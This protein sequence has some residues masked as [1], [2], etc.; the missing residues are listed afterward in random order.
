MSSLEHEEASTC[1]FCSKTCI[2]PDDIMRVLCT[3][4]WGVVTKKHLFEDLAHVHAYQGAIPDVLLNPFVPRVSMM[5]ISCQKFNLRYA[6]TL[7]L[8]RFDCWTGF[9]PLITEG[10]TPNPYRS[11]NPYVPT[12]DIVRRGHWS[13]C[14]WFLMDILKKSDRKF[15]RRP[16]QKQIRHLFTG[17]IENWNDIWHCLGPALA[18]L[19]CADNLVPKQ[20]FEDLWADMIPVQFEHACFVEDHIYPD[21]NALSV[22]SPFDKWNRLERN[23][24]FSFFRRQRP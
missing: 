9:S 12:C 5:P 3:F 18:D 21:N 17:G 16:L 7:M 19:E 6:E 4:A 14:L 15:Y 13:N 24:N 22:D 1:T 10:Y 23:R 2:L 8:N 20:W 11:D